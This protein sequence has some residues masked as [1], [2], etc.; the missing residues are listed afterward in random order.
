MKDMISSM[1]P[2]LKLFSEIYPDEGLS[3]Y[4]N[5]PIESYKGEPS[6]LDVY[7]KKIDTG[8]T[9]KQMHV[10]TNLAPPVGKVARLV[11]RAGQGKLES[12]CLEKYLV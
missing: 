2:Y 11:E 3:F 7:N 1:S 9:E 6:Y 5:S 10:L 4:L 8:L 12:K